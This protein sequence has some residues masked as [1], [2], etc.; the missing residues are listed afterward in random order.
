MKNK[1][2]LLCA[3]TLFR[4][5]LEV[6][7]GFSLASCGNPT[8]STTSTYTVTFNA[9]GGDGVVPGH[10]TINTGSG[11]TL[12]NEG[13]LTKI[14]YTFGGWNT[15][16]DGTGNNY[17]AGSAFIS[18]SDVILYARWNALAYTVNFHANGGNGT[19]PSTQ[20]VQAGSG[21]TLPDGSGL[22][23]SGFVFGGWNTDGSEAGTNYQPGDSYT[24]SRNITFY[25]VWINVSYTVTFD[26]NGGNGTVPGPQTVNAG[27]GITLPDGIGL[28]KND[29]IFGGWNT[30]SSGTGPNYSAGSSYIP[31]GNITLY[32]R[33]I[34]GGTSSYTVTFDV[35][36]WSETPP[37]VQTIDHGGKVTEPAVM[38][39]AGYTFSG[40]FK[41]AALANQWDF[42]NDVVIGNTTLYAKWNINQYTVTFNSDSETTPSEQT[43]DHGNRVTEPAAMARTGYAFGGWF[44]DAELTNQWI[45]ANDAVTD[46]ITLYAQWDI[47]RYTVIFNANRGTP[48]P[49]TQTIDHDGKVTEP[50]AMTRTGYTF[51]GW[52]KEAALTNQWNLTTDTVTTN[53]TLYAK[54]KINQYTVSFRAD[55]GTPAPKQQTI[56]HGG[57]VTEPEGISKEGYRLGGWFK[58]AAFTNDWD[59]EENTVTANMSLYAKWNEYTAP[60]PPSKKTP[61]VT[62]WP[63][64]AAITYGA[65]LS[66][67]ALTGGAASV[68]GTSV[69]G[70]FA[71][72]SPLTIPTVT[73]SG[74]QVTF[75]PT[76]TD[77]YNTVANNVSITVSKATP[78]I[79]W[80]TAA[81]I[82][83][84]AALSTS[85]LSG[86]A[87]SV[88]GSFDW[89]YPSTI[90]TVTNNG[91]SVTFTPTDTDNYN[92][93][94][95][96]VSITVNNTTSTAGVI[97]VPFTGPTEKI[98]SINRTIANNLSKSNGGSITLIINENFDRYEW[99]VGGANVANGNN[100]TLLASNTAIKT[101]NNWITAVVYTGTG[102][103]AIPWSGEIVIYVR[104]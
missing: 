9:N 90:P 50:A 15:R 59:F 87:A 78:T 86:G 18:E 29:Y 5:V 63:T 84:G 91:Y 38:D 101:G 3:G 26:I 33:W 62:T 89:S 46:N 65:A 34:T 25:T 56:N 82:I 75:T 36:G 19:P 55:G 27:S 98:I 104:E 52:F 61:V 6:V 79:T 58:E 35:N 21:I 94:V 49:A 11:I 45:F 57:R 2:K 80:P 69:P 93:V 103:N 23:R 76:D 81:T 42:A 37:S 48:A 60:S 67:S 7:I 16:A 54:W 51:D 10:Q 85:V 47:N 17:S 74:Y 22:S 92:T 97:N 13:G 72:S 24:P 66:T 68:G 99:F 73:N 88:P 20:T 96:T 31:T 64:A 14:D 30:D 8:N 71:W 70:S 95:N 4:I 40:W 77:N 100:V 12:P 32:A 39:R 102:T 28:E 43:V 44:I 83:Y 41:E 1:M 53:I